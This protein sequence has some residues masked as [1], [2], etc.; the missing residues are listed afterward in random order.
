MLFAKEVI[1]LDKNLFFLI[2]RISNPYLDSFFIS[3][4]FFG[5]TV[6]WILMIILTWFKRNTKASIYLI[7]VFILDTISLFTL[8]WLFLRPRPFEVFEGLKFKDPEIG[9]GPSFPSG[10]S[11]RAFSGAIILGKIYK[12]FRIIFIILAMLVA[13]SR[14]YIG[15]H[16]PLDTLIGSINGI[17]IGSISTTIPIEKIQKK[18]DKYKKLAFKN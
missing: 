4:T 8:K 10:H 17:I 1:T 11:E 7:Y 6:F 15:M 3:I 2:N 12:K 9:M 18:L 5:S 13:F 14:I 16:Y